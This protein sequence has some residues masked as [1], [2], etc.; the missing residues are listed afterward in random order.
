MI[1]TVHDDCTAMEIYMIA[2]IRSDE[3]CNGGGRF[4]HLLGSAANDVYNG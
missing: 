3:I 2:R 1:T 4:A